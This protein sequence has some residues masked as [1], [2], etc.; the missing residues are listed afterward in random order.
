MDNTIPKGNPMSFHES[1]MRAKFLMGCFASAVLPFLLLT[2]PGVE[3]WRAIPAFAFS[4]ILFWIYFSCMVGDD[5]ESTTDSESGLRPLVTSKNVNRSEQHHFRLVEYDQDGSDSD[6]RSVRI[7]SQ[8]GLV[9]EIRVGNITSIS[10]SGDGRLLAV[11][12]WY[13]EH[14]P[15]VEVYDTVNGSTVFSDYRE[16]E[17]AENNCY[18]GSSAD[19]SFI[20]GPRTELIVS[21]V[22]HAYLGENSWCEAIEVWQ[23]A[24]QR[25]LVRRDRDFLFPGKGSYG[26]MVPEWSVDGNYIVLIDCS[27]YPDCLVVLNASTLECSWR[28]KLDEIAVF[29]SDWDYGI[30]G[31]GRF[32][33]RVSANGTSVFLMPK[34]EHGGPP[35]I[36]QRDRLLKLSD[37]FSVTRDNWGVLYSNF[38]ADGKF[39]VSIIGS[40]L[41]FTNAVTFQIQ[42]HLDLPSLADGHS[43]NNFRISPN[44]RFA[45]F[46]VYENRGLVEILVVELATGAV[47]L[48]QEFEQNGRSLVEMLLH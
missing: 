1:F 9:N 20:P 4:G 36:V 43:F 19:V 17:R 47:V 33:P 28:C 24:K 6:D 2:M 35:L 14:R 5:E 13:E 16:D 11:G 25:L 45:I 30:G 3:R 15:Y 10:I 48:R 34:L 37:V 31:Y 22:R 23:P 7:W 27:I 44:S 39:L 40:R 38:T 29:V 26:A 46:D 12:R 8:T 18:Q 32:S 42:H 21:W 41:Y